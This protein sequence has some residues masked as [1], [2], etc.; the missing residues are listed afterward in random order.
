MK[1]IQVSIIIATFN[2]EKT[3]P[4]ALNSVLNQSFENWE[5]VIV[6]GVSK[7]GTVDII[8]D[9]CAKDKRFRYISEVDNGIY[10]AFNKGWKMAEGEWVYYLGS[11]DLLL[12]EALENF[13]MNVDESDVIYGNTI[14][15][16]VAGQRKIVSIEPRCLR[17]R[18]V[19]H[20]CIFMRRKCIEELGGFDVR[21]KYSERL[22]GFNDL[23]AFEEWLDRV[24]KEGLLGNWNVILAGIKHDEILGEYKVT[25]VIS[26][27][28]VNR[29]RRYEDTG[30]GTINI[31]VLRSFND[32]LS[33]ISVQK[34]DQGILTAMKDVNHNM[35]A[36]NL[37]RE[38]LG[39]SKNPQL[40]IYVIDKNSIPRNNTN[41]YPMNAVED[42]VGFS[43]NIPGI[44]KG[45]STIQSLTV[46][47]RKDIL[48]CDVV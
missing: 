18:M 29:T 15:E 26:I 14:F 27:N 24:S 8:K 21:Y 44:R 43:I 2:S 39:M 45:K 47:I 36:L 11:D 20:Q 48:E 10:D 3:L 38:E 41:R 4:K 17:N 9:Y 37:L 13:V 31:G 32:F 40:L 46:R 25:D 12:G 35:V 33:D 7:D 19:S 23:E 30:D 22:R 16:G 28:K 34:E 6:D 1:N 5:C 42:I